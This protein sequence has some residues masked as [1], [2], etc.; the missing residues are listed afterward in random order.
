MTFTRIAAIGVGIGLTAASATA[1]QAADNAGP[2]APATSV[3]EHASPGGGPVPWRRV[4]SRTEAGGRI[5]VV[6]TSETPDI[7]GRM[8]PDQEVVTETTRNSTA[9]EQSRRDVFEIGADGRRRLRET[10]ASRRDATETGGTNTV[11]DTWTS[12][13]NGRLGQTSRQSEQT[14]SVGTDTRQTETTVL[15]PSVNEALRE[16]QRTQ[17]IERKVD[18]T[19]TRRDSTQLDRDLN[20]RWQPTEVRSGE[21]RAADGAEHV[22]EQTVQRRDVSGNLVVEERS[23]TRRSDTNEQ[24]RTVVETYSQNADGVTRSGSRLALNQRV[25]TTT[26]P[27]ADGGRYTVEEVEG[28]NR[29]APNDPMRVV[30]RTVESVRQIGPDR[31]VTERQVFDLDVNGRMSLVETETV[32]SSSKP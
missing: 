6:S 13:V 5:I 7:N 21:A 14:R 19:V 16:T 20:G 27:S 28:R 31:W 12:D 23:V 26:T 2:P 11:H 32:Q 18:P 25:T 4:E 29:V 17:S 8:A 1:Q 24:D 9:G 3:I 30:R 10:T 15:V 22:E